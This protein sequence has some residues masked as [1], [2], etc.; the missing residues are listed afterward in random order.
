MSDKG[1]VVKITSSKIFLESYRDQS[2]GLCGKNQGCGNT[3]WGKFLNHKSDMI[4]VDN[5]I[6]VKQGDIVNIHY[7][8]RKLLK[9]SLMIYFV[10]LGSLL[11]FLSLAQYYLNSVG[12][13]LLGAIFGIF[14]G[15]LISR[16]YTKSSGLDLNL[17][18]S[19]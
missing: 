12:Y 7:D 19:K 13:S 2:C 10:P 4:A 3:L 16:K 9:V 15:I 1:I 17:T 18:I 8:E 5:N 14:F 11:F 6:E